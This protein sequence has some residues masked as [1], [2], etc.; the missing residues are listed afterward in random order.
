LDQQT[1]IV[2]AGPYGLSIAAHLRAAGQPFEL[3]GSPLESWRSY[4]PRGMW[5]K[6]ERF[7]SNLWDP[8]RRFSLRR[9]C[10]S[11]G[12]GWQAIGKP[13][14]LADFL[15]YAEWFRRSNEL[16]PR[17]LKVTRLSQ[18][19]GGFALSLSDG[20]EFTSRRV[21][22]ATGHMAFRVLPTEFAALPEPLVQ[23]SSRMS[24]VADYSGREVCI[25]GAG[26]SALETAA[27]LHENGARVRL[28]VRADRIEWNAPSKR[29]SLFARLLA[30]DAG[31][32]SGWRSVAISELPRVFRWYFSPQ[33]R[34]WFVARAYG[35]GGSWWLRERIESRVPIELGARVLAAEAHGAGL[36][37]QVQTRSG[38]QSLETAHLIA[39]TGFKVD[40]DRLEYLEPALAQAIEREGPGIPALDAHFG[41]S[42]PGLFIVGVASSPV[43]GPIM[44]FMYGAKHVAPV[45]A[46]RL[47]ATA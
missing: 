19:P 31:V 23:H 20:S 22:L 11:R 13:L 7:A 15:D 37:L 39:G 41:T 4:M 29:R 27:L 17:A 3:L 6:S 32:A 40:I 16:E 28:L 1:T 35:P 21:V 10:E 14:T 34:Q 12:L 46:H 24:D 38:V 47:L 44:R 2:G 26:Q 18:V 8:R 45:V 43:F 36:R 30:P 25:V 42:V 5:L 33:R 9:Y